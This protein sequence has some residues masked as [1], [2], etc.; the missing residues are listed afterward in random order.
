MSC[1][2]STPALGLESGFLLLQWQHL[3]TRWGSRV[4][5]TNFSSSGIL[6]PLGC[7]LGS[8]GVKSLLF[9]PVLTPT[10]AHLLAQTTAQGLRCSCS[11]T[12]AYYILTHVIP[13]TPCE[14]GTIIKMPILQTRKLRH[15]VVSIAPR[16]YSYL[17]MEPRFR[18]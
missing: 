8:F 11:G 5:Q 10:P 15:A 14:G 18:P 13:T 17:V 12:P 6:S 9:S 16:S 3:A 4:T 7:F 1:L 2:E